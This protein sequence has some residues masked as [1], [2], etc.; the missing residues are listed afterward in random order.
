MS[1]WSQVV[2]VKRCAEREHWGIFF[3]CSGKLNTSSV[4]DRINAFLLFITRMIACFYRSF[5]M[6]EAI[7]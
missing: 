1:K 2:S 5:T 4:Y 3:E 6:Y 7:F